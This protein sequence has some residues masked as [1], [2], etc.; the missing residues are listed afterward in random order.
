[1]AYGGYTLESELPAMIDKRAA[2]MEK[3]SE[4][5]NPPDLG[6]M[7]TF[8]YP[9]YIDNFNGTNDTPAVHE[10][11]HFTAIKQGG[12]SFE[13]AA[14]NASWLA[15]KEVQKDNS[16]GGYQGKMTSSGDIADMGIWA[17]N[18][19]VKQIEQTSAKI[20]Q[21]SASKGERPPEK[22]LSKEDRSLLGKLTSGLKTQGKNLRAPEEKL[23]HCFLYM[24]NSVQDGTTA[25]WGAAELGGV[26]YA[27]KAGLR[28]EG[29]IDDIM[30]NFTGGV[31]TEVGKGVAVAAG[32]YAGSLLAKNAL[33]GAIGITSAFSGVGSGLR[34]AGRFAQNPYEEQLFNGIG[35]RDFTFDFAFAPSSEAEGMQIDEIIKMFRLNSRPNFVGGF[36]GEGLYTFPN[37]FA[38]E[39][40]M[41]SGTGRFETNENLPYIHNCVC[42][43]VTTNYT[44]EGFWAALRDGRPVSYGL[45]LGFV[46]TKKI[47]QDDVKRGY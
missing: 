43:Q 41:N 21:V 13:K 25:S 20:N 37:E 45:S 8:R 6:G 27:L 19:V 32:A 30:K 28:G 38:I 14:D 23:A 18:P 33:I 5:K 39:F 16:Y 31:A 4:R 47:T 2:A 10:C 7:P 1:M 3:Q 34:A 11:I 29:N 15:S 44:P 35:F 46:E 24:P 17:D 22:E 36:M 26:G 40:L 9:I 42:T 12:L